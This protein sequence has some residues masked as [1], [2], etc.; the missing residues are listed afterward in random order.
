MSGKKIRSKLIV[1][2]DSWFRVPREKLI[3]IDEIISM[4]HN[5]SLLIDDIE[6]GSQRRRGEPAASSRLRRS[7]DHQRSRTGLFPR[8]AEGI[9]TRPSVGWTYS[10]R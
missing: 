4:L 3:V 8:H 5:A 9:G 6:D 7:T 2:F 10:H 1:A